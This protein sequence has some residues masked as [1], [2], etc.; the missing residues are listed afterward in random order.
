MQR[1]A[2]LYPV[3]LSAESGCLK[4]K[5]QN[6]FIS[7]LRYTVSCVDADIESGALAES[8]TAALLLI[9]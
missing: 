5:E 4:N 2:D 8:A 6:F 3:V 1:F 9:W 7:E